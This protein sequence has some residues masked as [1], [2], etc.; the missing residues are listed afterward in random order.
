MY[1]EGAR[2][3]A[4][5]ERC[6]LRPPPRRRIVDEAVHEVPMAVPLQ[7][8]HAITNRA[9]LREHRIE[10]GDV[11]RIG[12]RTLDDQVTVAVPRG[13]LDGGVRA[14]RDLQSAPG[15][16]CADGE[17]GESLDGRMVSPQAIARATSRL[18]LDD[19]VGAGQP[20]PDLD[21]VVHLERSLPE[22]DEHPAREARKLRYRAQSDELLVREAR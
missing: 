15:C 6:A 22:V 8:R 2:K 13:E 5:D 4:L 16:G 21:P 12:Q 9:D 20:R 10:D 3:A 11:A 17:L 1:G 19:A 7:R 14:E 18:P